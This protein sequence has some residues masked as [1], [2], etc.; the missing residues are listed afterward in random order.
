MAIFR[1]VEEDEVGSGPLTLAVMQA[2]DGTFVGRIVAVGID[3]FLSTRP[4]DPPIAEAISIADKLATA[5]DVDVRV[6]DPHNH[7]HSSWG[8]LH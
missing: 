6:Y 1:K 5:N 7:W 3:R 8:P 4:N 2:E